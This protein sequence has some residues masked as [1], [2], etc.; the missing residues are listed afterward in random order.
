MAILQPGPRGCGDRHFCDEPTQSGGCRLRLDRA[1]AALVG[2]SLMVALGALPL[3]FRF[4]SLEVRPD[5][6]GHRLDR[7]ERRLDLVDSPV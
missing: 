1:V 5:T 2:A 6:I 7:I 4:A 3:E